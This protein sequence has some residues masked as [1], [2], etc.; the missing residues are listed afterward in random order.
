M[1]ARVGADDPNVSPWYVRRM[2][3]LLGEEGVDVD[4]QEL[5]GKQHWV[6]E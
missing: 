5:P 1:H 6:S 2:A 4:Y 3:R